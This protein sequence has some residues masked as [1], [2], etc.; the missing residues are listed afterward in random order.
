VTETWPPE[1][2]EPLL[3]FEVAGEPKGAGS[4]NAIPLGRWRHVDGRRVF[5]PVTREGGVPIVNVVD[6][7]DDTGGKEWSEAIRAACAGALDAAH[8]LYDG[9]I[10]VRVTFYS[11]G[12]KGRYGTGRN[13]EVLKPTAD[14]L[15]HRA[16]LADGTKLARRLEDALN[17]L[18]WTDDRRVCDMWWSR[19][20][21]RGPGARV[22]LY[23]MPAR[24]CE[25]PG[26]LEA[27]TSP[28]QLVIM[29]GP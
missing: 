15:P 9:P 24:Y 13:A 3:S 6:T 8:E 10:A 4:K 26:E 19:R 12:P 17:G 29:N 28:D 7:A 20:F 11:D 5:I 18:C 25:L 16:E 14:R 1:H 21:G 2:A 27:V 23:G 22:D